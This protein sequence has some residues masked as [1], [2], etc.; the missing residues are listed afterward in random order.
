MKRCL[1]VLLCFYVKTPLFGDQAIPLAGDWIPSVP[2]YQS[3][4][5]FTSRRGLTKTVC[6]S[7]DSS[8]NL[9]YGGSTITG[10]SA[11]NCVPGQSFRLIL[12]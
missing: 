10:F 6:R 3:P 7:R 1:I 12:L 9:I 5:V 4:N 8:D 11:C 2:G